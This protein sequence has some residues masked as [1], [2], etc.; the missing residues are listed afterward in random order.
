MLDQAIGPKVGQMLR[1]RLIHDENPSIGM[2]KWI[3]DGDGKDR[4]NRVEIG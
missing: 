4:E 3:K 2:T 1:E